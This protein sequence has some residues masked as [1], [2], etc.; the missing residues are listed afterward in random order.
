MGSQFGATAHPSEAGDVSVMK[1]H[2]ATASGCVRG[3][4]M[5]W[6]NERGR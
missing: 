5:L 4:G 1:E 6:G 3:G 2:R